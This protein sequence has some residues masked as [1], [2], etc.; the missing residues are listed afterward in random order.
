VREIKS[1]RIR[2]AEHVARIGVEDRFIKGFRKER[3]HLEI[4][5]LDGRIILKWNM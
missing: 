2:L 3:D 4:L 1:R 5:G